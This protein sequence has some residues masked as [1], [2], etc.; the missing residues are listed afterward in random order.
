MEKT[1][2]LNV[3][4][5]VGTVERKKV[6]KTNYYT[7]GM[8]RQITGSSNSYNMVERKKL[9]RNNEQTFPIIIV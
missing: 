1:V 8:M 4:K 5:T 3:G 6:P 7:T 2:G 9:Y